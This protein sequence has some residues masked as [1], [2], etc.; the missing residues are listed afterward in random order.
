MDKFFTQKHCDRCH[1]SLE[2]GR[3]MSMFSEECICMT[4][5]EKEK[6]DKDYNKAV[7]A[8]HEQIKKGNYNFKGIGRESN[9]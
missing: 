8:D 3:I 9:E 1:G 4:C 6:Q 2:A 5:A 7:E